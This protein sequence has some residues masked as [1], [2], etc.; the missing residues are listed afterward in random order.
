VITIPDTDHKTVSGITLSGECLL[1]Q[2][3]LQFNIDEIV[4]LVGYG[5]KSGFVDETMKRRL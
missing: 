5:F 3:T 2:N 4:R 1:L